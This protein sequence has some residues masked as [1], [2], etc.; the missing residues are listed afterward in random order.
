M[1]PTN[2]T[3]TQ[4]T[5]YASAPKTG[6]ASK[7]AKSFVAPRSGFNYQM[8]ILSAIAISFVILGHIKNDYTSIGSL[9]GWFPY[10]AFHLPLFLFISGYFFQEIPE[11][12]FFRFFGKFLWKKIKTLV[13]P[14]YVINSIF[15]I[16]T[17]IMEPWGI[18]PAH[19]YGVL[20]WLV[21]P[22]IY[23]QPAT[24]SAPSWYLMALFFTEIVYLLLRRC[25]CLIIRKDLARDIVIL[26]LCLLLSM[27][28]IWFRNTH[29][30]SETALVYLRSVVMLAFLPV[31][32]IY[33]RYLEKLDRLP[34]LA[35]FAIAFAI[36]A[37]IIFLSPKQYPGFDLYI[38]EQ[39]D[40]TGILYI[41]AG[42]T[43]IM[44]W[45]RI[46]RLIASIPAKSHF[47]TFMGSNTLFIMSFH[48][49][50]MFLLNSLLC[51]L[52]ESGAGGI[53]LEGFDP[54]QFRSASYYYVFTDNLR[55]VVLYFICGLFFS[56]LV[57]WVIRK[58]QGRL[59]RR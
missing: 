35:Y 18:V 19:H 23:L 54:V 48:L 8:C 2:S 31:G 16:I 50:G 15:L 1:K 22:F 45:L 51:L 26:L 36:Q 37:A 30:V 47:L 34:S 41:L 38:M 55:F 9:F 39:F 52:K 12:H 58:V 17:L 7:A 28:A 46:S 29:D 20:E 24:Y 56:L 25:I 21:S 49:F 13:I 57:A 5:K 3:T 32:R 4:H 59:H 44:L 11:D 40:L 6:A 27:A 14:F 10:Y 42:L 53:F 43:G 33:R